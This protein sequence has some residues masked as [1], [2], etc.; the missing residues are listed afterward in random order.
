MF[1]TTYINMCVAYI[2]IKTEAKFDISLHCVANST[3]TLTFYPKS[4]Q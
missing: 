1:V 3:F 2:T 4:L